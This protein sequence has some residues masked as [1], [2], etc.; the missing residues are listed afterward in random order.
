MRGRWIQVGKRQIWESVACAAACGFQPEKHPH[1]CVK[2][3]ARAAAAVPA[4][5]VGYPG[6]NSE[7]AE[8]ISAAAEHALRSQDTA[9]QQQVLALANVNTCRCARG[10]WGKGGSR[11]AAFLR[12]WICAAPLARAL[13]SSLNAQPRVLVNT[14]SQRA[15]WTN[16]HQCP[17]PC[18]RRE[19]DLH[20]MSSAEARAAVLCMLS[21]AWQRHAQQGAAQRSCDDSSGQGHEGVPAASCAAHD[22]AIITGCGRNS[23]GGEA[24][25][26]GVVLKLL[27]EELGIQVQYTPPS[28][29]STE[30]GCAVE[31]NGTGG[32]GDVTGG[33]NAGRIIITKQALRQWLEGKEGKQARRQGEGSSSAAV[34]AQA[35]SGQEQ[36]PAPA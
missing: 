33:K 24:V 19:I 7:F 9:L 17:A 31:G 4:L 10:K 36:S 32:G 14:P 30:D 22:V 20:G 29:P 15:R 26:P 34:E 18:A 28:G 1:A 2:Q 12:H 5:Q 11:D 3:G 27:R 25:L 35:C 13:A 16:S 23:E 21:S 8:L 6:R